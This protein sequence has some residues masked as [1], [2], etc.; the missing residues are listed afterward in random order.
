MRLISSLAMAALVIVFTPAAREQ[1]PAE[2]VLVEQEGLRANQFVNEAALWLIFKIE[3]GQMAAELAS[4]RLQ[5][6]AEELVAEGREEA[7]AFTEAA[8]A[9]TVE[10]DALE[11]LQTHHPLAHAEGHGTAGDRNFRRAREATRDAPGGRS[12]SG[13]VEAPGA[14]AWSA[15]QAGQMIERRLEALREAPE[16][17]FDAVFLQ[18]MGEAQAAELLLYEAYAQQG[19]RAP[20]QSYAHQRLSQLED[21]AARLA[22]LADE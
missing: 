9:A 6:Y 22:A 8:R 1:G 21:S 11:R 10:V 7:L 19:E 14:V 15:T 12:R 13:S 18:H 5:A 16:G 17:G 2:P 20:L 3:A 4:S